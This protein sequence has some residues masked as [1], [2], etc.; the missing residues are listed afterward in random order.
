MKAGNVV[1]TLGNK[2]KELVRIRLVIGSA[3]LLLWSSMSAR[4]P[5][6]GAAGYEAADSLPGKR[7]AQLL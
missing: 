1:G 6:P 5:S 3:W 4:G 7:W 2:C